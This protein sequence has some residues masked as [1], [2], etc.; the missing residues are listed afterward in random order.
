MSAWTVFAGRESDVV[1]TA[2]GTSK[3]GQSA[4]HQW[5][6]AATLQVK[7]CINQQI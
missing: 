4:E 2:A 6:K 7:Q 3:Q 5:R 1:C